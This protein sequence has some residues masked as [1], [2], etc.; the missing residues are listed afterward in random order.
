M[1]S[2]PRT[3]IKKDR[4]EQI[5][6]SMIGYLALLTAVFEKLSREKRGSPKTLFKVQIEVSLLSGL[7]RNIFSLDPA[8]I[9][10][11]FEE[12]RKDPEFQPEVGRYA[13]LM[14][15]PERLVIL[16]DDLR[17][18]GGKFILPGIGG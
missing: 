15:P 16:P 7:L 4:L 10:T 2:V 14:A 1:N 17:K 12:V 13:D 6:E 9:Q 5:S 11:I 18:T 8:Y 3:P